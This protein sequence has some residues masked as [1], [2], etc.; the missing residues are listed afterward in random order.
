MRRERCVSL[1]HDFCPRCLR[2]DKAASKR[3]PISCVK[4]DPEQFACAMPW[5]DLERAG[6]PC[7][8][9][10]RL[11]CLVCGGVM[12][13]ACEPEFDAVLDAMDEHEQGMLEIQEEVGKGLPF[14][15]SLA[16]SMAAKLDRKLARRL[17]ELGIALHPRWERLVHHACLRR[18]PCGCLLSKCVAECKDHPAKKKRPAPKPAAPRRE[19]QEAPR[20]SGNEKNVHS[21]KNI[22]TT[23]ATWLKPRTALTSVDR[24]M[25]S[26]P[27]P[28]SHAG[29]TKRPKPKEAKT[30]AALQAAAKTC[31]RLDAWAGNLEA[32]SSVAPKTTARF[33]ARAHERDFDPFVHGYWRVNGREEYRFPDGRRVPVTS[34]VH[35]LTE[36]GQL[37]PDPVQASSASR[38]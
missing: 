13:L 38:S 24:S 23:T 29:A 25:A 12:A 8:T 10:C 9:P 28:Y 20:M 2:G 17:F 35:L 34:T 1:M 27:K 5:L 37:L 6:E 18:A 15:A 36:D 14:M 26:A 22:A 19:E 7:A 31:Q 21:R 16:S 4:V 33:D 3:V 32:M 30:N 11:L